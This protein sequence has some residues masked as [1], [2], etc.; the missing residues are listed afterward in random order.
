MYMLRLHKLH[1]RA[2]LTLMEL[3][4]VIGLI[5]V[6][7]SLGVLFVPGF[8]GK[9][10]ISNGSD[11]VQG[12]LFIAK[13]RA[14][15][16]QAARGI[17]FLQTAPG[18]RFCTQL[19]YIEQVPDFKG[20]TVTFTPISA[21]AGTTPQMP[22]TVQIDGANLGGG[23]AA[24]NL[25]TIQRDDILE[26]LLD[27]GIAQQYAIVQIQPLTA[28]TQRCVN[29]RV[30]IS[31]SGTIF[32]AGQAVVTSNYRILRAP[33]PLAGEKTVD[34]PDGVVVD[35]GA[36][37]QLNPLLLTS[38]QR[39]IIDPDKRGLRAGT[40]ADPGGSLHYDIMFSPSGAV[41]DPGTLV[42]MPLPPTIATVIT[43]I[44]NGL[45][46]TQLRGQIILWVRDLNT[47]D[48][49]PT[50]NERLIVVYTRTGLIASHPVNPT[51]SYATPYSFTSDGQ[52][53]GL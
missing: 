3:L 18:S 26:V 29:W 35:L 31:P 48:N 9:Q 8:F 10:Q 43:N 36:G 28:P 15:R 24:A 23:F 37:K 41:I 49:E 51:N 16:E 2:G 30:A 53:S 22:T 5:A 27:S 34:L 7:A 14:L 21:G 25:Y 39:S 4:V 40:A 45:T 13:Q 6:L 12:A 1:C 42:P 19:Q 50:G 32:P 20:G 33:R 46:S 47:P 17:R 52:T 44:Q 38:V 11:K